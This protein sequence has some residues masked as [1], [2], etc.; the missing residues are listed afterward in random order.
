[1]CVTVRAEPNAI[2]VK[3][4]V[5]IKPFIRPY[6]VSEKTP[7]TRTCEPVNSHRTPKLMRWMIYN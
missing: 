3:L 1:M 7:K 6:E 5:E 4:Y 2:R